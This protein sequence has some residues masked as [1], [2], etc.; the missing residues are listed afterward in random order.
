MRSL[1]GPLFFAMKRWFYWYCSPTGFANEQRTD[2]LPI[3]AATHQSPLIRPFQG[4][5]VRLQQNK[6]KNLHLAI[7]KLNGL[8][9]HPGETLS[10]WRQIGN[11]TARKGYLP[12][13][14]LKR[15]RVS[16]GIGGGLCQLSNLIYWMT[17]HTPLT[18]IERWRHSY[19]VFPDAN[20]TLPFGSGATCSYP[21]ID[22]Q[23]KNET[24]HAY[25]LRLALDSNHL[26]GAWLSDAASAYTYVVSEKNHRFEHEI[27]GAYTRRNEIWRATYAKS[28]GR[29]I[30]E[31][32]ITSNNAVMMYPP[33]LP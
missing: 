12:G 22:L 28:D 19:D 32:L 14:V 8:V 29:L 30:D 20:R 10:Y 33:L 21:N 24:Q 1:L 11:P 31:R 6:V 7:A 18:V 2:S 4:L 23:I 5:D 15:G 9:I 13:M 3:Q 26:V 16:E 17:L 25:Q 27:S